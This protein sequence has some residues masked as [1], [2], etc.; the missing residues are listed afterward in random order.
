MQETTGVT[1]FSVMF[2]R[3]ARLPIDI[4]FNLTYASYE[5]PK[6][7]QEV[8]RHRLQKA[9][10]TVRE[11]SST[12]QSRQ[13]HLYDRSVSGSQYDVGDEVWLHCPVVPKGRCKKFHRPWQG[14]F[15][16]LKVMDHWVYHIQCND[17][18]RKRL[19]VHYNR[20]KPYHRPFNTDVYGPDY[21]VHGSATD[22]L[23]EPKSQELGTEITEDCSGSQEI[24]EQREMPQESSPK[25]P[26]RRSQ[27]MRRPPDRY[28]QGIGYPDCYTS[29]SDSDSES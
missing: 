3:S 7:Y 14:P 24:P 27:R 5:D 13:K 6:Q 8:L 20:L 4:E 1:P 2:G 16:I 11:H 25:P 26:L 28:G 22:K 23:E 17:T 29:N 9:Y 21:N 19:V 18:P 10:A 15:T 12:E